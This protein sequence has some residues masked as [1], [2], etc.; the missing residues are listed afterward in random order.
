M[1][2]RMRNTLLYWKTLENSFYFFFRKIINERGNFS[3]P[4]YGDVLH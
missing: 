3:N 4:Q 1:R 2:Q